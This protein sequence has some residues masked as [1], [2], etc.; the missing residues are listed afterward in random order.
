[1]SEILTIQKQAAPVIPALTEWPHKKI[2]F[3]IGWSF[4]LFTLSLVINYFAGTYAT[5]HASSSVRDIILD[6]VPTMDVDGIFIYGI[7][8]FFTFVAALLMWR[9]KNTPFILKTFSL[10]IVV[11]SFFICL[12]HI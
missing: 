10:F 2:A 3:S 7:V 6:N 1:M 12:T 8:A 4:I 5:A 11:R 9:P